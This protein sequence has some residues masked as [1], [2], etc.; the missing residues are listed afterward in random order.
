MTDAVAVQILRNRIASLMEEMAHQFF[1]SGYST[2][3]R[4][5]R[6]FS[7]V[8]LDAEGRLLVA[9]AMF[10]HARCYDYLV[11][12]IKAVGGDLRDGDVFVCNHPYEGGLPHVPDMAVV[13]PVV[14][15]G[16]LV[17]FA[18]SIAH[19]ADLG[20]TVPGSTYGQATELF[21]EGLLV[22]PV[23]LVAAGVANRDLERLIAA[24]SRQPDLVLGDLGSQVGAVRLG[25]ARL[26]ALCAAQGP[27]AFRAMLGDMIAASG[28]E[29]AAA[30]DRL[31]DGTHEAEAC[32]DGDGV[33]RDAPVRLRVRVTVDHG[34]VTFDFAGSDAQR[35]GPVNLRPALVEACCF[36]A[37]IALI[38]PE[39]RYSDAAR[40]RVTVVTEPGSVLDA[41][42][43]APCSSYM[44]TCQKLVDVV[45]EAL[46]PFCPARAAAHAGGSGG[47]LS[48][49]WGAGPR[50][51]R[52]NQYEIFGSAYGGSSGQDGASGT[53]V[54]LSNLFVTPM[55]I[56]ESEFPCRVTRFELIPGSGGDG[57]FRGGLSFRREYELLQ[58][59]VVI[60]RGDR[61]RF[62]PAGVAG[63]RPG[64][65]SRFV[66][67]APDGTE[68][69]MPA[70]CRV[71]LPAGA[72]IRI[73]AAGGGG[74]GD[75]AA[76]DPAARAR[77]AEDGYV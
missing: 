61:A 5:S 63:G 20:G 67:I 57:A 7:C 72:R 45:I 76:R 69:A 23:R 30:L 55:E 52:G 22:P 60:Y 17:G 42:L 74:Y 2:I 48:I 14:A 6:D 21:H 39:L 31:P 56:V 44:V 68:T 25:V 12:R 49:A 37:L 26:M 32:L 10:Y 64:R 62:A 24:N 18:G 46:N 73:E 50:A 71:E 53:A 13:A 27:A 4:E 47:A 16:T 15:D 75:P 29:F 8:I 41:R 59:A 65:A 36:H 43:P 66:V 40:E 19:K 28:R 34:R 3:V 51:P 1:R 35:R 33:E 38:D 77:D 70:S 11:R 54:H 58:P 9:P